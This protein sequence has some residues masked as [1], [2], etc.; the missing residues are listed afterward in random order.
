M[1]IRGCSMSL[2][3][4]VALDRYLN[5]WIF[6]PPCFSVGLKHC[7]IIL[8]CVCLFIIHLKPGFINKLDVFSAHPCSCFPY[9][10]L[11][12]KL[13][14]DSLLLSGPLLNASILFLRELSLTYRSSWRCAHF[15]CLCDWSSEVIRKFESSRDLKMR[16]SHFAFNNNDFWQFHFLSESSNL[17]IITDYNWSTLFLS[18]FPYSIKKYLKVILPA[19]L[20]WRWIDNCIYQGCPE[21]WYGLTDVVYPKQKQKC[22]RCTIKFMLFKCFSF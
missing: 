6:P 7:G 12:W 21:V 3:N 9:W 11:V 15:G 20:V 4:G 14:I 2:K 5:T 13:L 17:L 8:S 19:L 1:Q 10:G 22:Q 16:R 18:A